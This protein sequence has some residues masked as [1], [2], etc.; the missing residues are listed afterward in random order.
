MC[1]SILDKIHHLDGPRSTHRSHGIHRHFCEMG[2]AIFDSPIESRVTRSVHSAGSDQL[3]A[4]K[5][6]QVSSSLDEN[7]N[8][9]SPSWRLEFHFCLKV[10]FFGVFIHPNLTHCQ[11]VSDSVSVPGSVGT[12]TGILQP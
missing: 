5:W 12:K 2:A 4:R 7:V 3:S 9:K 1:R 11:F 8:K 6:H 10:R